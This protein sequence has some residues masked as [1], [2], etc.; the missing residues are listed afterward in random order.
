VRSSF[1][2]AL[3]VRWVRGDLGLVVEVVMVV[4]LLWGRTSQFDPLP[5]PARGRDFVG[6]RWI[7]GDGIGG[8]GDCLLACL[9]GG[10][11]IGEVSGG[12]V[13]WWDEVF[14]GVSS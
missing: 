13:C 11:D 10:G 1:A 6:G 5:W 3:G 14:L 2:F 9:R 12:V 8:E 4:V 7:G